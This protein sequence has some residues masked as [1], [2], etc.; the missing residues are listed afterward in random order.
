[1]DSAG[2][3]EKDLVVDQIKNYWRRAEDSK[4]LKPYIFGLGPV[5]AVILFTLFVSNNYGNVVA[6]STLQI[7][8]C[9]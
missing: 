9:K 1:M 5:V 3:K 4:L 6:F 7:S 8:I 2:I